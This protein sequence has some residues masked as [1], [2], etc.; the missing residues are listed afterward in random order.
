MPNNSHGIKCTFF[1]VDGAA[2]V[3]KVTISVSPLPGRKG[4]TLDEE[5]RRREELARFLAE[6]LDAGYKEF[7]AQ[8]LRNVRGDH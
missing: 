2:P 6:N 5:A 7:R 3:G 8:V 4:E 1:A